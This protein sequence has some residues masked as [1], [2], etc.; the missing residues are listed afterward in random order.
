MLAI[1]AP[2][3]RLR[4]SLARIFVIWI[5]L[6]QL[7]TPSLSAGDAPFVP[8]LSAFVVY[9]VYKQYTVYSIYIV[10]TEAENKLID[11]TF[12]LLFFHTPKDFLKN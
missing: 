4:A 12:M 7:I 5:C 3:L 8:F 9:T 10:Y 6:A 2:R 11:I 1:E